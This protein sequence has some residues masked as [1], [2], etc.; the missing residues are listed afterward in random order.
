MEAFL[1]STATVTLAEIG[2]KTQL[3]SLVLAAKFRNK[4]AIVLGIL[5]ATIINHALSA[6]LGAWA[7]DLFVSDWTQIV[8]STSFILVGL[9]L[10]IPDKEEDVTSNYDKYGAFL[11]STILFFI[12][13]IGDKTQIATV[14]LGAEYT[15]IWLVTLGT[16]LGMLVANVPV[17]YYGE[18][19]MKKLP[20]DKT[21]IAAAGLFIVIGVFGLL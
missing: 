5:F 18:K 1:V 13:E 4:L 20:L 9:W 12:A 19:L 6:W 21:R 14:I 10:L 8:V 2:D 11:V 15:A 17:V 3:L 16:T 7:A